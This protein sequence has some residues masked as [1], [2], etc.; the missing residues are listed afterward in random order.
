M[1][2]NYDFEKKLAFIEVRAI[3]LH[4]QPMSKL[5]GPI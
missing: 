1:K 3:L 2:T 4:M 5:V